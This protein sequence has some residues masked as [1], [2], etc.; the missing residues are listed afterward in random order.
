[1]TDVL[2]AGLVCAVFDGTRTRILKIDAGTGNVEGI[3]LLD[4]PFV[5][6][7]NVVRGWLTG[8]AASRPVAIRLSTREVLYLPRSTGAVSVLSIAGDRLYAIMFGESH[9]S[10]RLYQPSTNSPVH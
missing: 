10:V 9:F 8:W 4:G 6:D 5:S 3:G 1:M 2:D 7:R